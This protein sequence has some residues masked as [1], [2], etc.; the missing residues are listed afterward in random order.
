MDTIDTYSA[1]QAP[2]ELTC[3]C[4]SF[5]FECKKK[6]NCCKKHKTAKRCKSCPDR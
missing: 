4:F 1:L 3:A 6:K 2:Q 5:A